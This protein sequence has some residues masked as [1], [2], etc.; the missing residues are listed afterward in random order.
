M[1]DAPIP[2]VD[3]A[4]QHA[5]VADEVEAGFASVMAR[6]AFINAAWSEEPPERLA[7]LEPMMNEMAA[8]ERD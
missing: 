3:L 7:E 6:T 5:Q 2:L 4:W 8:V 1:T